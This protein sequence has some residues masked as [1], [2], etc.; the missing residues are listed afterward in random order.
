[1]IEYYSRLMQEEREDLRRA[2]QLLYRQTFVLERKCDRRSSRMTFNRDYRICS[3]HLEFLQDYFEIMGVSLRENVQDGIIYLQG[4]SLVG[5]KMTRTATL[6]LLILKV[7]YDEQMASVSN[8][9]QVFTTLGDMNEK[10]GGFGLIE[11]QL[12]WS[13]VRR[14]IAFLKRFQLVEPLDVMEEMDSRTRLLIY[15]SIHLVLLGDDV[16]ALLDSFRAQQP[17]PGQK[18]ME[19][20]RESGIQETET[21]EEGI[22]DHGAAEI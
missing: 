20:E 5:D 17:N 4:E 19:L 3:R 22:E 18:E 1:M 9:S 12:P 8:S 16:R 15:P 6:Y 10:L 2:V 13:D 7:I 11:R 21:E 14:S